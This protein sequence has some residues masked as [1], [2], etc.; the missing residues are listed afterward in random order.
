MILITGAAGKTGR[1][2]LKTLTHNGV[3]VKAFVRSSKQAEEIRAYNNCQ[4][5]IGDLRDMDA[6]SLAMEGI[7]KR[8]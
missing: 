8:Y 5:S 2:I 7:E 4:V 3:R 1:A 6:L